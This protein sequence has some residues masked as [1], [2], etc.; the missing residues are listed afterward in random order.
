MDSE[1]SKLIEVINTL[2]KES[3]FNITLLKDLSDESNIVK[4]ISIM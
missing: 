1:E 4:I 2:T 3:S